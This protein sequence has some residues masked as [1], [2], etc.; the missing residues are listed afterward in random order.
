[1]DTRDAGRAAGV[2]S[3]VVSLSGTFLATVASPSFS[4]RTDALSELGATGTAAGTTLTV[5]LFN[6]GLV[7]GA[8]VG[9]GFAWYLVSTAESSL[10][11][12]TG[13]I[14]GLATASM[15]GVGLFP[16]GNRLHAPVALAY[17]LLVTVTLAVAGATG[18]RRSSSP[19]E[20]TGA[21]MARQYVVWSIG[22]AA[23]NVV[24]WVGWIAVGATDAVGLAIPEIAS[25]VVF[26]AWI[27]LTVRAWPPRGARSSRTPR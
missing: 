18:L 14:F 5:A 13:V 15:G 3:V 2:V 24:V 9:L 25:S 7:L 20:A 4:W 6:G 26:V 16:I 8:L 27:V 11:R 1:M 23:T 10:G 19:G 21:G 12:A 22:L 17:F